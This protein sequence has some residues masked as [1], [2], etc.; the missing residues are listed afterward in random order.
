LEGKKMVGFIIPPQGHEARELA[1]I[2]ELAEKF[3]P[4]N[5]GRLWGFQEALRET[6][7]NFPRGARSVALVCLRADDERW[8]ISV[9][10]RG[11]WRKVWNYGTGRCKI[12][13]GSF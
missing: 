11:G 13:T 2:H 5:I 4:A 10:P 7:K 12:K 9:G 1:P 8:L 3:H 6:R